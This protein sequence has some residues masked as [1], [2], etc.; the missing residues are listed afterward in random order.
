M[1]KT[2]EEEINIKQIDK[3]LPQIHCQKCGFF[4][5]LPYAKA[6]VKKK[7][8]IYK[9]EPGGSKAV[10]KICEITG[11]IVV[12]ANVKDAP[13]EL[14]YIDPEACIGCTL[15][16]QKC[17]VDAI[18]GAEGFLHTV[19]VD[20]CNGCGFCVSSCPV[21]CITEKKRTKDNPWTNTK[22]SISKTKFYEKRAR[23]KNLRLE[24]DEKR[25]SALKQL[26]LRED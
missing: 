13:P 25:I 11:E 22:A 5:C 26:L 18:A 23:N 7:A 14:V 2:K 21:D 17:P 15:C 6:I 20:E 12:R 10:E 19:I 9:C 16:I 3:C 8:N 24:T 4:S 1:K